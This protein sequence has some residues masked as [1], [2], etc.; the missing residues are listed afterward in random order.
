MPRRLGPDPTA[1][2]LRLSLVDIASGGTHPP[3]APPH[4]PHQTLA[5]ACVRLRNVLN[6]MWRHEH[7]QCGGGAAAAQGA[8]GPGPGAGAGMQTLA[9]ASANAT[10]TCDSEQ[11]AVLLAHLPAVVRAAD[12]A[13]ALKAVCGWLQEQRARATACYTRLQKK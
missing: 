7:E 2:A 9:G 1:A 10:G 6:L 11:Q 13:A 12:P 8:V 5:V 4:Q 3:V